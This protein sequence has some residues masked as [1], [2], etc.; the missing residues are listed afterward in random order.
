MSLGPGRRG[1]AALPRR[2]RLGAR[3][4]FYLPVNLKEACRQAYLAAPGVRL[5]DSSDGGTIHYEATN[6]H[7]VPLS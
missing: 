2:R 1:A 5:S 4:Q 7:C 3:A 6:V